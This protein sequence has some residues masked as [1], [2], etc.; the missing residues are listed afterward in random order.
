MF[1]ILILTTVESLGLLIRSFHRQ[2][3]EHASHGDE[4]IIATEAGADCRCSDGSA[5]GGYGC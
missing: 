5:C 4:P 1:C 2:Q 3:E